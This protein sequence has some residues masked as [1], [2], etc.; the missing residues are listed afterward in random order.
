MA[1]KIDFPF[2]MHVTH[3]IC[4]I[5]GLYAQT[6]AAKM[7]HQ[8]MY[9]FYRGNIFCNSRRLIC[10]YEHDQTLVIVGSHVMMMMRY[11][12]LFPKETD[13]TASIIR[14]NVSPNASGKFLI[15]WD[16]I[17]DMTRNYPFIS[18][19]FVSVYIFFYS[20]CWFSHHRACNCTL[21]GSSELMSQKTDVVIQNAW[22][23][24]IH[25]SFTSVFMFVLSFW[26]AHVSFW[27]T[28]DIIRC[29]LLSQHTWLQ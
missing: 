4:R 14:L 22:K 23:I 5:H 3:L 26:L 9:Y 6:D 16:K 13:K 10:I 25:C 18:N 8:H 12:M 20:F 29:L 15:F 2:A 11:A 27:K 21:H 17:K 7:H 19:Y 28:K 1:I 24:D